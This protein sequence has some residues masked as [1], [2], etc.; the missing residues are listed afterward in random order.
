MT[1]SRLLFAS[2]IDGTLL[3]SDRWLSRRTIAA[4]QSVQAAGHQFVL[5]S[6]RMPTSMALLQNAYG[7]QDPWTISYNGALVQ[8]PTGE[9]LINEPIPAS[10]CDV[11]Y[12]FG[13]AAELHTSFFSGSDW[14]SSGADQWEDRE[15]SNTRVR[16]HAT[17]A[18]D[19]RASG[20]LA[21]SPIHK[22]M[23]MGDPDKIDE[24]TSMLLNQGVTTYRSKDTY[25]EIASSRTS[26]G[27]ALQVV[28][29]ALDIAMTNVVYFGDGHNDV[30]ALRMAGTG[31]AV[32][33][34]VPEATAAADTHAGANIDDGVA[35]FLTS[36]I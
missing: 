1:N 22:I 25:L 36:F 30:S 15:A 31:V 16:P 20:E 19:F 26:K 5:C 35:Q 21:T 8:S 24:L 18:A 4:I 17:S 32:A 13:H 10:S 7:D 3:G 27:S 12:E 23:V 33:N 34:A 28:A 9:V 14:Y 6:S 11:I 29:E 2:D